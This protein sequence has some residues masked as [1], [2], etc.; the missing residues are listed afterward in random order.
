ME[1]LVIL[2]FGVLNFQHVRE[3]DLFNAIYLFSFCDNK[4]FW[5]TACSL[6]VFQFW[7]QL[8]VAPFVAVTANLLY[9]VCEGMKSYLFE[10]KM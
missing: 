1:I 2:Y 9:T 6:D 7:I 5:I 8:V 10:K 3:H 4:N